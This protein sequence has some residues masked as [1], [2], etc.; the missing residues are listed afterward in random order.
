MKKLFLILFIIFGFFL[1]SL[2]NQKAEAAVTCYNCS[3]RTPSWSTLPCDA[4]NAYQNQQGSCILGL[5]QICDATKGCITP[6]STVGTNCF[7]C[8]KSSYNS[9]TKSC[10]GYSEIPSVCLLQKG[11]VCD[12]TKGCIAE[13]QLQCS[14]T[15]CVTNSDCCSNVCQNGACIVV[16]GTP[17]A[18][19]PGSLKYG[20]EFGGPAT[21]FSCGSGINAVWTL[22]CIFPLL[23]SL[24][25]WA[26]TLAGTIG[27]IFII[28][29]GIRYILSGGDPK[30]VDQARKIILFAVVGLVIIF[31]SFF[32][33]SFIGK[34]TGVACLKPNAFLSFTSCP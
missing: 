33:L 19:S 1:F 10:N 25:F 23:A 13:Q 30:K 11:Q 15:S 18:K 22:D 8:S 21:V 9:S 7:Y 16:P 24:I 6:P 5:G 17:D 34:T 4:M 26:L 14:Y 2:I 31:L 20:G 27:V 28:L 29:G 12:P 32:I 3:N